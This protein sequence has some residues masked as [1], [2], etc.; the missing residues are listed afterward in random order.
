MT[1]NAGAGNGSG[2]GGN[3]IIKAGVG[4]A[5]GATGDIQLWGKVGTTSIPTLVVKGNTSRVSIQSGGASAVTP[6]AALEINQQST[7]AAIPCLTLDQ[8]DVDYAFMKLDGNAGSGTGYNLDTE[9]AGDTSGST[10]AAPH[11][12]AWTMGCNIWGCSLPPAT[13]CTQLHSQTC[14]TCSTKGSA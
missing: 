8:D 14:S 7:T 5:S 2:N 6:D 12:A 1:M 3:T 4:G 13:P 11:S 9:P 10:V